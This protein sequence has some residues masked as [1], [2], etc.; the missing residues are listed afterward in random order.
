MARGD[1]GMVVFE[2]DEDRKGFLF[3][4]G[5][6][7]ECHGWRVHA[8]VLM[9]NHFHLLVETPEANLSAGITAAREFQSGLEPAAV[10]ARSCV[11]KQIQI[12]PGQRVGQRSVLFPDRCSSRSC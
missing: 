7:C 3:R 12:H 6:V 11:P 5:K 4:L 2:N 10:E 1:G 9:D 8:W